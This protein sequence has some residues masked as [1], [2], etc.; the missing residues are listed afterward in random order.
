MKELRFQRVDGEFVILENS[1]GETFRVIADDFL[2]KAL[3]PTGAPKPGNVSP[4][5]IQVEVRAG[6]GI[7]ELAAKTGASLEYIEKFAGPV[8][9]ELAHVVQTALSVRITVAGDRYSDTVQIEF[10]DMISDRL[11]TLGAAEVSWSSSKAEHGEWMVS[12]DLGDQQATW[13]FDLRK[14]TLSPENELA[15]QLSAQQ[16]FSDS[17]IPKLKPMPN[18]APTVPAA[19]AKTKQVETAAPAPFAPVGSATADLGDTMEFEGVIPFGRSKVSEPEEPTMGENLANTA[20]LLDALRK[21]RQ[22]REE[23]EKKIVETEATPTTFAPPVALPVIELETEAEATQVIP[24]PTEETKPAAKKGRSA[25][26]SW[27]DIVFGTRSESE[28]Q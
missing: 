23:L 2:K 22:E 21:K 27:N 11:K 13:S 19:F 3:K 16:A 8:L 12:C 26:P 20:D 6:T 1:D 28:D 4:R 5:E 24:E 25:V 14:L 9:D 7:A 15:V 10:G 18:S 17:P